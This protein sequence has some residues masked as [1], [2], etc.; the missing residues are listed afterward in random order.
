M[1]KQVSILLVGIGGYGNQYVD[2]LLQ[3]NCQNNFKIVGVVDPKPQSCRNI[4]KVMQKGTPIYSSMEDF[5]QGEYAD[6]VVISTPIQFHYSQTCFALSRGS[7]VLCE[8]PVSAT[9][10]EAKHMLEARYRSGKIVSIGYQWSYSNAIRTLKNDI[11]AGILG[12]PKRFKTIIL[13]PRNEEY[14]KRSWAG[15]KRGNEGQWILDS[16]ANN[17]TAHYLHN[18][19]Y[20]LGNKED[21]SACPHHLIAELYRANSIENFDTAA[22]R[23]ITQDGVEL[24]FYATH[25]VEELLNP[26]FCFEFEGAK[27]VYGEFE[28]V[29]KNIVA[30]FNDGTRKIYGDPNEDEM[31]KIWMTIDAVRE[32]RSTVCGI[33]AATSHTLCINGMQ[34]SVPE[35]LGFPKNLIKRDGCPQIIWVE[36]LNSIFK[37]CYS[38][39]VLPHEIG[40]PWTRAGREIDLRGYHYFSGE[41]IA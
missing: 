18:M 8:K 21:E 9:I 32:N 23:V 20:V 38:K 22:V 13:W 29:G 2:A 30:M 24:L 12:Q 7:N 35:I 3:E 19:F 34:E 40:V 31:L 5:Y 37:D 4:N 41:G 27:V 33:E 14:F 36:G 11:Q 28:G 15:R 26:T 6:L 39:W 25:A 1:N 17:A 10:Q 16:V